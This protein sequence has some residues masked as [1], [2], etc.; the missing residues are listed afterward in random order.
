MFKNAIHVTDNLLAGGN[1]LH[2]E[3]SSSESHSKHRLRQCSPTSN[4]TESLRKGL[5]EDRFTGTMPLNEREDTACG[6]LPPVKDC[7]ADSWIKIFHGSTYC[8]PPLKR[9][10]IDVESLSRSP[11]DPPTDLTLYF[12]HHMRCSNTGRRGVSEQLGLRQNCCSS[13][14]S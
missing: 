8:S 7:S 1:E 14:W 5:R 9:T 13:C 12:S 4:E 11:Q 3:R 10:F 6:L 2:R